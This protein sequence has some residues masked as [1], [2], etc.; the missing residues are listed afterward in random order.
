MPAEAELNYLGVAKSLEMYGVD[1]HPVYVSINTALM[2]LGW[3][4]HLAVTNQVVWEW[5]A[6]VGAEHLQFLP[7]LDC[8]VN[9]TYTVTREI[10]IYLV[11]LLT[12]FIWTEDSNAMSHAG[13]VVPF[14]FKSSLFHGLGGWAHLGEWS[15]P[16][17]C[18]NP[19]Q[20]HGLERLVSL[21]PEAI[22]T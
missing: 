12:C 7:S 18:L 20:S 10:V 13:F 14:S 1:L 17:S 6:S 11:T 9:C 2:N 15:L 16:C 5:R 3:N 8:K 19:A 22:I 21:L 4:S